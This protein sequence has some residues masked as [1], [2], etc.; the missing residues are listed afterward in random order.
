M[1]RLSLLILFIV[2]AISC[3]KNNDGQ[4]P[5]V[6][7]DFNVYLTE[8]SNSALNSVG[9]WVYIN[10]QGVKGIIIYHKTLDEFAAYERACPYD[11]YST[12]ALIT[13]DSSN[14]FAVDKEHCGSMYNLLDG[15]VEHG[16]AT[17]PLK[18]YAAD[19][20]GTSI[21]RVHN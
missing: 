1:K 2:I 7:V 21:I 13:V 6:S 10:N 8:P 14:V 4:V 16:P 9:N 15:S 3:K 17:R 5:N 12:S 19:Y 20:D 11:Y 18:Q